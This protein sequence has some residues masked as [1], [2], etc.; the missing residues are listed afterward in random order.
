MLSLTV[1][2]KPASEILVIVHV[3]VEPFLMLSISADLTSSVNCFIPS[4]ILSL[5]MSISRIL[6]LTWFPFT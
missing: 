1:T 6:A 2:S 3:T 4:E 5:S